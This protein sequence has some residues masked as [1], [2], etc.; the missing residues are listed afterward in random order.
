[1]L[2]GN[3]RLIHLYRLDWDEIRAITQRGEEILRNCGCSVH[4]LA[5]WK[6]MI[7]KCKRYKRPIEKGWLA[8]PLRWSTAWITGTRLIVSSRGYLPE[9]LLLPDTSS[10]CKE[11]TKERYAA[12]FRHDSSSILVA[13]GLEEIGLKA[14]DDSVLPPVEPAGQ[15]PWTGF[16]GGKLAYLASLLNRAV[17]AGI[18]DLDA[19][20]GEEMERARKAL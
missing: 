10:L 12:E 7:E 2:K 19:C 15:K 5:Q 8:R 18:L 13:E 6:S 20:L 11:K 4:V 16:P 9:N 1:V 3:A 17:D 14:A